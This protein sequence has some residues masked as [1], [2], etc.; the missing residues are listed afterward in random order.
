MERAAIPNTPASPAP[1][2]WFVMWFAFDGHSFET[3]STEAE[4]KKHADDAMDDWR[5]DASDGGWDELS[6]QVCYG[7]VT[8]AV[9]VTPQD[10]EEWQV[11]SDCDGCEEHTL[12]P[13][14]AT[15]PGCFLI[16]PTECPREADQPTDKCAIQ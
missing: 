10:V 5:D 16:S 7:K 12:E 14:N 11:P 8:H 1:L 4:A 2:H 13:L 9:T 3:F 15:C 6:T